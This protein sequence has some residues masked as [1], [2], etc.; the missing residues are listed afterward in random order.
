MD[1]IIQDRLVPYT[2]MKCPN[3]FGGGYLGRDT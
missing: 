2:H 3:V 1:V